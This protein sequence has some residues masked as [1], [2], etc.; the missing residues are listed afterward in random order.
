MSDFLENIR[1]YQELFADDP[2]ALWENITD[3]FADLD[4]TLDDL[5][6]AL[7]LAD[8]A[9]AGRP[10]EE[11]ALEIGSCRVGEHAGL[12]LY[13]RLSLIDDFSL[14]DI[15]HLV[16]HPGL[17]AITHLTVDCPV[18]AEG[19]A[20]LL[21]APLHAEAADWRCVQSIATPAA[22]WPPGPA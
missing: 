6:V 10:A 12:S 13:R 7:A 21:E 16:V 22:L 15:Q 5:D 11:R 14:A 1:F 20:L 17:H 8:A 18:D 19:L 9:L 2:Q 3:R 4:E